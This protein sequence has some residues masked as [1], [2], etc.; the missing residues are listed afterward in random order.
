MGFLTKLAFKN[1]FRYKLRT[2]VSIVAIAFSVMVV[3]FAR[4]YVV[5]MIDSIAAE[6]IQYD[7]GHIKLIDRQYW[8]EERLLSL[9]YPID[10]LDEGGL[11]E[12]TAALRELEDVTMVIP[13][14][15]FGAMISTEE[16][17]IT[18]SGWV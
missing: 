17:L 18:I 5:G 6:H 13:R 8:E 4:G 7:S 2:F 11:A 3:V 10:G 9:D 14:L 1:L 15:K 12:M 16:E